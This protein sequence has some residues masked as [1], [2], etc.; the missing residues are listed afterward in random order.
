MK[1]LPT[2]L[3]GAN[4]YLDGQRQTRAMNGMVQFTSETKRCCLL[5]STYN[6]KHCPVILHAVE[7]FTTGIIQ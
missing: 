4:E 1:T 6:G 2:H 7:A 3:Q 5:P